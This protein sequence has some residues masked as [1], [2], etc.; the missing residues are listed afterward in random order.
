L[1]AS[2]HEEKGSEQGTQSKS[3][4]VKPGKRLWLNKAK[5]ALV[6]DGHKD[7]A[8]LYCSENKEVLRDEY[9]SLT[10]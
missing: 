3:A 9:E 4:R 10:K 1:R 2:H 7:A 6:P 8:T 5:D